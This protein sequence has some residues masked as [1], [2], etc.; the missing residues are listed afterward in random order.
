MKDI[1]ASNPNYVV[2]VVVV[3]LH[4]KRLKH[5]DLQPSPL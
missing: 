5:G 2:N 4:H 1:P 3:G